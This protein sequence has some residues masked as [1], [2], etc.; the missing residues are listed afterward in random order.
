MMNSN[1]HD[2]SNRKLEGY[3]IFVYNLITVYVCMLTI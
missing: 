1:I 2:L 3:F